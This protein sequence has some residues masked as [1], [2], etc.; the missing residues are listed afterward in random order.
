MRPQGR[1][2]ADNGTALLT[3]AIAGIGLAYLPDGLT[4]GHVTAGALVPVTTRYPPPP[5]GIFVLRSPGQYP[6]RKITVL[7]EMLIECFGGAQEVPVQAL[8]STDQT[9]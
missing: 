2:K 4:D 1:F 5:A 3:A 6:A 7:T 8:A 9:A